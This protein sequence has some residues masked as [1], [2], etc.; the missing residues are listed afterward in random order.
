V[1]IGE[2]QARMA[3]ITARFV[4]P[5]QPVAAPSAVTTSSSGSTSGSS[6]AAELARLSGTQPATATVTGSA[7]S[8]ITEAKAYLGV[9]YVWG[10]TNP[11]TG[12]DC[13]GLTQLVYGHAGV[14]LPRVSW[15]QAKAGTAV[16]GLANAR[17]GDLLAFSS[18]VDHVAIYLGNNQM[19]HA[20]KPGKSVEI[21]EVYET[22]TAIR[23]VL[24]DT[25]V[26]PMFPASGGIPA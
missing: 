8:V 2:V 7:A 9:P 16:D 26:L 23:R 25:A 22:P 15:E 13:S 17:P 19:I 18:P 21:S 20:P 12:L 4:T 10:G 24:P 5:F 14:D 3:A 6:F 1:S 11:A